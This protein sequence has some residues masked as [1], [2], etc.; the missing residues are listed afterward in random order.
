MKTKIFTFLFVV[1]LLIVGTNVFAQANFSLADRQQITNNLDSLVRAVNACDIQK[2]TSLISPNNPT[3]QSEI[4]ER[5]RC[6]I[7]YQLNYS[8]SDKNFEILSANKVKVKA[9]FAASGAGWDINGLSTFFVF[10]K[11]GFAPNQQWLIVDTNFHQKLGPDYVWNFL[12]KIFIIVGPIF[13][14]LFVFWL[15]MLI[16]CAKRD[17]DDKALWIILLIFLNF[18]AAA[19]YLFII[20]R[21]NIIR[22]PLE[23]RS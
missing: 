2:I 5:L 19:L 10:E 12:K 21:K 23:F 16:D 22:K 6:G 11:Q 9:R 15:W 3:L 14:L 20:K 1:S 7:S 18:I 13:L 4:Q 17:F 8:P